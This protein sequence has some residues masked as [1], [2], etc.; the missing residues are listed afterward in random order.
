MAVPFPLFANVTPFGTVPVAVSEGVGAPVAVTVKLPTVPAVN[1][2][3]VAVV[4]AGAWLTVSVK[5]WL[6]GVPTP[7]PAMVVR[8]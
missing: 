1:V 3:L 8:E 6:T 2:V 4:I 7:L 5:G